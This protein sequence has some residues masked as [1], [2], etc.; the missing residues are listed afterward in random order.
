[1]LSADWRREVFA[2]GSIGRLN[3]HVT[4]H[5]R[6]LSSAPDIQPFTTLCLHLPIFPKKTTKTECLAV[7]LPLNKP[8]Y[9]EWQHKNNTVLK[10][11]ATEQY[12]GI[13]ATDVMPSWTTGGTDVIC[14]KGTDKRGSRVRE[15]EEG[16]RKESKGEREGER[17]REGGRE[18]EMQ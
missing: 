6:Q 17:D 5:R 14:E 7:S 1:M 12:E 11:S 10:M 4:L 9:F 2:Q 8:I 3:L 16:G 13:T 18:K 15:T